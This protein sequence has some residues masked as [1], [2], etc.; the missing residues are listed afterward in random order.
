MLGSFDWARAVGLLGSVAAPM[1]GSSLAAGSETA[2]SLA[3]GRLARHGDGLVQDSHLL[4]RGIVGY[5]S[6]K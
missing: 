4:P 6:T 5:Y 1:T 2:L 3:F